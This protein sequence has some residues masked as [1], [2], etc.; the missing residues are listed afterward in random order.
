MAV[1]ATAVPTADPPV[2]QVVGAVAWGPKT[3]KVMVPP[4]ARLVVAPESTELMLADVKAVPEVPVTGAVTVVVVEAAVV[5]P[6]K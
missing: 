5:V 3:A 6:E 1:T 2:V 4:G